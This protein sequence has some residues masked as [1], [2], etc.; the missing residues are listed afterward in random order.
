MAANKTIK[1]ERA[2]RRSSIAEPVRGMGT[3]EAAT[4]GACPSCRY[5]VGDPMKRCESIV[6]SR[7]VHAPDLE[8]SP[9][10]AHKAETC[11]DV[12]DCWE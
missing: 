4:P 3:P 10:S 6:G 5:I 11:I 7:V 9:C 8:R 12:E 2:L 1:V